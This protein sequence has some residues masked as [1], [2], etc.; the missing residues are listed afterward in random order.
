MKGRKIFIGVTTTVLLLGIASVVLAFTMGNV[1]GQWTQI[2]GGGGA[3]DD[4]W[5]TGPAGGSTDYDNPT[6]TWSSYTAQS[7][8]TDNNPSYTDW[9]QVRYGQGVNSGFGNRSGFGFD[10]VNDVTDPDPVDDPFLLGKWCHFNNPIYSSSNPLDYV[11]LDVRVDT[12]RC[13]DGSVP[14]DGAGDPKQIMEFSYRFFLDETDNLGSGDYCD[15]QYIP[16]PYNQT[17]DT[18]ECPYT[19]GSDPVCPFDGGING[20]GCSDAV[21]I[22][23]LAVTEGFICDYG[24][25]ST[26][27]TIRIIGFVPVDSTAS[28]PET[29]AGAV[30]SQY[31]SGEQ[32]DS[33][34]CLYAQVT[35]LTGTA[36]ELLG[37]EATDV[38]E[39]T[40]TLGWETASETDNLGFNLYRAEALGGERV[41]VNAELIPTNVPPGSPFGATYSY[42]DT[43]V[44]PGRT[45]FYWLEDV[46]IDGSVELHGPVEVELTREQSIRLPLLRPW[47]WTWRLFGGAEGETE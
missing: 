47:P 30:S 5:A 43:D 3:T 31:I 20:S 40:V 9:N 15:R 7:D 44:E 8:Y 23:A 41:Q 34:A 27:Y 16:W 42:E 29:P 1:D 24:G 32:Q 35:E 11:D 14:E 12:I 33:C 19:V 25:A 13:P 26:E 37:F 28:C 38:A 2:D 18:Y 17:R 45:Y 21:D 46:D 39:E 6:T 36:V 4:Y 22:G 10:G